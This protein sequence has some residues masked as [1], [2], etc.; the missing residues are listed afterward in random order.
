[1]AGVG[2]GAG[3]DALKES[4]AR[5]PVHRRVSSLEGMSTLDPRVPGGSPA[6]AGFM[7]GDG[8]KVDRRGVA[9][10]TMGTSV[11]PTQRRNM[12]STGDPD[13]LLHYG[14]DPPVDPALLGLRDSKWVREEYYPLYVELEPGSLRVVAASRDDL[15]LR[16]PTL[17][18]FFD[19]LQTK[20]WLAT[21]LMPVTELVVGGR[22]APKYEGVAV[23]GEDHLVREV[24]PY[25]DRPVTYFDYSRQV[26]DVQ[27]LGRLEGGD[28]GQ[29][30]RLRRYAKELEQLESPFAPSAWLHVGEVAEGML[31]D[32]VQQLRRDPENTALRE[33][34]VNIALLGEVAKRHAMRKPPPSLPYDDVIHNDNAIF[35]LTNAQ[36]RGGAYI[37]R[38][39]DLKTRVAFD[40]RRRG[41]GPDTHPLDIPI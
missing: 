31:V 38:E 18:D 20:S 21:T 1:M 10:V 29:V 32:L 5:R 40:E 23:L 19:E 8:V 26:N 17:P 6:L 34:L 25:G 7:M 36:I 4:N 39:G 28:D 3:W 30:K 16:V 22:P 27:A 15:G 14:E 41:L 37:E 35:D 9:F 11:A 24:N 13:D 12:S 33:H 2:P